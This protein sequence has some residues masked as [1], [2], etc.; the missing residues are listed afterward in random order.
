MTSHTV[1]FSTCDR[2]L[3][4]SLRHYDNTTMNT[5][6]IANQKGGVGKTTIT[7]NLGAALAEM[8]QRTLLVDL[9]PQGH[10]TEGLGLP[11]PETDETLAALLLG[12]TT[13]PVQ[14]L[15][16][17]HECGVDVIPASINL[18]LTERD[19]VH[20]RG[21]EYRLMRVFEP[22]E[23]QYDYTLIDCPPT[24]GQLTDNAL[25]A[26]RKALVPIQPEDT[27]LRAL[28]MLLDQISSIREGLG[29]TV[30]IIGLV[31]NQAD[32]TLVSRRTLETLTNAVPVP[33]LASIRR[34]VRL[35]EAW[36]KGKPVTMTEPQG[37]AAEAFRT[38]AQA[39]TT[40]REQEVTA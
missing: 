3:D 1:L 26:A 39:L 33:V 17:S 25:V 21:R 40:K 29:L 14:A 30:E 10:L 27:S 18:F 5:I 22:L 34:R 20:L 11:E 32:D 24:L 38:L 6:A 31:V 12:R 8:G 13:V 23:E 37:D 36:A 28:E 4:C 15:I 16:V 35:K 2:Y 9:D 19:L 7:I